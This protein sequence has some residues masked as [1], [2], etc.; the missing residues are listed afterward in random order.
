MR[1]KIAIGYT[2]VVLALVCMMAIVGAGE[3]ELSHMHSADHRAKNYTM[4]L[5]TDMDKLGWDTIPVRSWVMIVPHFLA[6]LAEVFINIS[7]EYTVN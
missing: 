6:S 4:C 3:L 1:K 2:L 7:C 5:F